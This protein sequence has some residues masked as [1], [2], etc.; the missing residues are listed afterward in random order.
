[1]TAAAGCIPLVPMTL[2]LI[3][4]LSGEAGKRGLE[5][6]LI[7]GQAVIHHGYPRMTIDVDFLCRAPQ[8]E[9]WGEVIGRYGYKAY[10]V[11]NAFTQ[12]AGD[13]GW[14]KVDLMFVDDQTFAKLE[15]EAVRK[16]AVCI[17]SARHLVALK[18]HAARSASRS[19]P[20]KDWGDIEAL[21]KLH[22]LDPGD[23][24]FRDIVLRYGGEES[25][26]RIETMWQRLNKQSA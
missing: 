20:E 1:M 5:F 21:V 7:G 14:P 9:E 10:S 4:R 26:A 24:D 22:R 13:P 17:P 18:L 3:E 11:A 23:K 8:R 16:G 25:L 6:L 15:K 12:F 2:E 19:E